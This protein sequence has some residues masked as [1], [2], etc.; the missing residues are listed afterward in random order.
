M[1]ITGVLL[2]YERQILAFVE[3]G[4]FRS[5]PPAPGASKLA[6]EELLAKTSEQLGGLSRN[7][8]LTLRSDGREPA[9]LAVGGNSAIYIQPY[10]GR[11]LGQSRAAG[12]R[13]FFQQVTAWHRWLGVRG[14]GRAMAKAVTGACN[15]AFLLLIVTGPFLWLP[16][17]WTRQHL[18]PITWFRRGISGKARDFNWHNVFG[19]WSAVPLFFVVLTAVPMSYTWG[20][21]LIY[22]ITGTE[23]PAAGRGRPG[24]AYPGGGEGRGGRINGGRGAESPGSALA[25]AAWA[26]LNQLCA[27][28]ESQA[29]GW[30]SIAIRLPDSARRPVTFS[31][32][33]GDGGQ[34]QKRTTLTLDRAGT[35]KP[36]RDV[37]QLKH[38]PPCALLVPV[39]PHG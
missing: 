1:C 12:W 37:R 25:P 31:I 16:K 19:I 27:R 35:A 14:E 2:M 22:K 38:R 15:L 3:R 32:D 4:Q 26:G 29:P 36:C 13:N 24:G 5:G 30:R 6:V 21:D 39:C 33:M 7:A 9:E 34:P 10:T 23:P 28:A 20:N 18:T 17:Q 8:T 11:V